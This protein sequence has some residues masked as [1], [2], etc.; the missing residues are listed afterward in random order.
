MND[1]IYKTLFYLQNVVCW[2]WEKKNRNE[3]I[4]RLVAL[5]FPFYD[6]EADCFPVSENA[7]NKLDL[8]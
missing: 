5:P 3:K 2:G 8:P 1:F 4:L 6:M 7:E